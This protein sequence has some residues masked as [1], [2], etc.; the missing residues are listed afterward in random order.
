MT[1]TA[2]I[3]PDITTYRR[4]PRV[5]VADSST[6]QIPGLDTASLSS[7]LSLPSMYLVPKFSFNILSIS[8]LPQ[9][10]NFL[11]TLFPT[12][13]IVRISKRVRRLVVCL[14][15]GASIISMQTF[16]LL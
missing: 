9:S 10:L 16:Q 14:S 6:S 15:A 1:G 12:H 4:L 13:C 7:F 8:K 5:T 2:S 3:L 11:V